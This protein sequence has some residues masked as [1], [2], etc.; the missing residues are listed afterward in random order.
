LSRITH[1]RKGSSKIYASCSPSP[2]LQCFQE[3][4]Q[5]QQQHAAIF[6]QK[7]KKKKEIKSSFFYEHTCALKKGVV[8]SKNDKSKNQKI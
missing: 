7:S 4:K 2:T 3:R 8:C 1:I 5:E 6:N